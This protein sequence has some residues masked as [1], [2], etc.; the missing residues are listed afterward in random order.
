MK[1]VP[2]Q[3]SPESVTRGHSQSIEHSGVHGLQVYLLLLLAV[4]APP[5]HLT[6]QAPSGEL[7]VQRVAHIQD[8]TGQT[9]VGR[10]SAFAMDSKGRLIMTDA[11]TGNILLSFDR[12]GTLLGKHGREGQ[13]P[14][15]F[16]FVQYLDLDER[17]NLRVW[18]IGNSRISILSPDFEFLGQRPLPVPISGTGAIPLGDSAFVI[19]QATPTARGIGNPYHVID[20]QG[21][22]SRSFGSTDTTVRPDQSAVSFLRHL[23]PASGPRFWAGH[24]NSYTIELWD[25]QGRRYRSYTRT[26]PWFVAW[27]RA[28][29]PSPE[30]PQSRMSSLRRDAQGR[31]WVT[32]QVSDPDWES[33]L[34][35]SGREFGGYIPNPPQGFWDTIIEVLDENTGEVLA[36]L[37]IDDLIIGIVDDRH[38]LSYGESPRGEPFVDLWEVDFRLR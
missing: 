38:M 1:L 20:K 30:G 5:A 19:N 7:I 37:R 23:S 34:R 11:F 13:G 9:G 31:L 36:S 32:F 29:S 35:P 28:R 16:G 17:G 22:T 4:V 25:S 18:D 3:R 26:V 2:W 10:P 14:G 8:P 12:R 33:A 21:L 24:V 15:E 6:S 27:I